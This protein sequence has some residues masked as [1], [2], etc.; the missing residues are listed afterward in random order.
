MTG[1][2]TNSGTRTFVIDKTHSEAAFQVRH[3]HID[4]VFLQAEDVVR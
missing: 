4:F 3:T 2:S 1:T